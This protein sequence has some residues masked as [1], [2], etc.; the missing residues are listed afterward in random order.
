MSLAG[1]LGR[2]EKAIQEGVD[3]RSEIKV[4]DV[5]TLIRIPEWLV[6]DLPEDEQREIASCVGK[7]AVVSEIDPQGNFWIGFGNTT[8]IGDTAHYSGH[9]FGVPREYLQVEKRR[10]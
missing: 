9:S 2:R 1:V 7:S 4:G 10:S 5:V 8:E 3:L 6:H